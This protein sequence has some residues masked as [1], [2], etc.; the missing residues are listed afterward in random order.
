MVLRHHFRATSM[1]SYRASNDAFESH[2]VRRTY[3]RS[4]SGTLI[5]LEFPD[6]RAASS[7]G[8]RHDIRSLCIKD[9]PPWNLRK[10]SLRLILTGDPFPEWKDCKL[11]SAFNGGQSDFAQHVRV[12][13]IAVFM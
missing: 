4:A 6:A 13:V 3:I 8:S 1:P 2:F 10:L 9:H 7:P 11:K 5:S 12:L